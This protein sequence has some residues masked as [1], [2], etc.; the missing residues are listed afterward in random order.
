MLG[1]AVG[2]LLTGLWYGLIGVAVW[3]VPFLVAYYLHERWR[4]DGPR[5][6]D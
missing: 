5:G 2:D 6:G 3:G 4:G 1:V